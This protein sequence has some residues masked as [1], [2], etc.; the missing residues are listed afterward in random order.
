[1]KKILLLPFLLI[2]VS[3][4]AQEKIKYVD[5]EEVIEEI[6]NLASEKKYD[7]I[8]SSLDKIHKNDSIYCSILTTK[9]YYLIAQEKYE[10]ALNVTNE[11][12]ELDCDYDSKLYFLIN[13]GVSLKNLERYNEAIETYDEALKFFPANPKLWFN[14]ATC[15]ID[16]ENIPKAIEALQ[17]TILIS[18]FHRNA[19][20]YLGNLCYKQQLTTQALMCYNMALIVEPDTERAFSLLNYLNE[21]ISVK[22]ES[23]PYN[24]VIVSRD[25]EAFEDI[26]LILDNKIALNDKYKVDNPIEIAVVKQNHAMLEQLSDFE[27]NGDFWDRYYVQLFKWISEND[28]FDEFT[29]TINYSIKNEKFQKIVSKKT[30]DVAGFLRDLITKYFEIMSSQNHTLK[31]E[32]KDINFY[33]SEQ[34]L[35][36]EGKLIDNI[37]VGDWLFYDKNGA[38]TGKGNYNNEGKRQGSWEWY[39][40]NGKIK[41]TVAYDNGSANGINKTWYDN[42]KP[43]VHAMYKDNKLDGEYLFYIKSGAL[44]QKKY[45]ESD[46]LEGKYIAYF[47]VGESIPE[48]DIDYSKGEII[49][50]AKE[51]YAFGDLYSNIEFKNG[52]RNGLETKYYW[53]K[54]KSSEISFVNG[55]ANGSYNLYHSNGQISQKGQCIDGNYDGDWKTYYYNGTLESEFHY[56][57]G[58]LSELYKAYDTD[59]KLHYEFEY[60]RGEIISYRYFNKE[61]SVIAENRK[62][63][64]KFHFKGFYPN[65]N[66]MSEGDYDIKGGKMGEWKFYDQNSILS[67]EGSYEDDLAIGTHKGYYVNGEVSSVIEYEKGTITGYYQTFFINGKL[68]SQGWYK[69]GNQHGE[70]RYYNINGSLIS[71]NF[72]HNGQYNGTQQY[73]GANGKLERELV[74]K[75]DELSKEIIYNHKNE[76]NQILDFLDTK[77]KYTLILKHFDGSKKKEIEYLNGIKHGSY[78]EYD[79]DG[80]I[81]ATGSYLN[82]R[83][84][85]EWIWY[86]PSGKIYYKE[87]YLNGNEEGTSFRYYESGQVENEYNYEYGSRQG[88]SISYFENGNIDNKMTYIDDN[89]HGSR[90]F[91]DKNGK[92]QLTRIYNHGLL[93]GYTYNDDKGSEKEMIPIK[94]GTGK[95][96]AFYDNGKPSRTMEYKNGHL[97]GKYKAYYYSGQLE[98]ELQYVD[99]EYNGK[100]TDYYEDG[101]IKNE[102][103]YYLG[104]LDGQVIKNYPNGKPKEIINYKMGE[105]H[106]EREL[107]DENGKLTRKEYY[108]NDSIY[109]AE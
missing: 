55:K 27:G 38:L 4:T 19:H 51:F 25:D 2:C 66:I 10:E 60:R 39:Y 73:F 52:E 70:W 32:E 21:V 69:D 37:S 17:K 94:N 72:Y 45:F 34:V 47:D 7:K 58:K 80:N 75:Y 62:R 6:N 87:T 71:I 101:T 104:K 5:Y 1:M 96:N 36:A 20:L 46:Q 86:F 102:F 50:N 11:A 103:N 41:E 95:I 90:S 33:Y 85:G 40:T 92:L 12:L 43:Q 30:D 107:Y 109:K 76:V 82:N 81:Y 78:T 15:Y 3:L 68:K 29:Y 67:E 98:S 65:G 74:Y 13:K 23:E 59:G 22:N 14:K 64:G 56:D 54:Q 106:G 84:N 61:G 97:I 53:N 63:G 108:Y 105:R 8:I 24:D 9:S 93:I 28:L 99:D 88:E 57:D 79:I 44:K 77:S 91:Y 100:Y 18:P 83:M 26:D 89:I 16:I 31:G 42:G 48:F 49:N 35:Q